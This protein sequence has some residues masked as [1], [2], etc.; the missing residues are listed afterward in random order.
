MPVELVFIHGWGFDASFWDPLCELLPPFPQRRVDLGFFGASGHAPLPAKTKGLVPPEGGTKLR[1]SLPPP[2]GG[3]KPVLVGHSLGFL[4]GVTVRQDWRGWVAING[5]VR[6]AEDGSGTGCM[7]AADLRA[8][9]MRLQKNPRDT[10]KD[11]YQSIEAKPLSNV[12]DAARLCAGLDELR[13][14][15]VAKTLAALDV[16]GLALAAR[17]DP[18]VPVR[19]SETLGQ[20]ASGGLLWHEDGGHNMPQSDAAWCARAITDFLETS[21]A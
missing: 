14:G 15:D 9:K 7:P 17:N 8:M 18:L 1:F 21:F 16:P 12:P 19:A 4:H 3:R 20:K 11:F 10:L 5:F 13:D 6:F 2:P